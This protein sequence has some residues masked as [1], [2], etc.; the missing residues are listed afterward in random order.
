MSLLQ[1]IKKG[2]ASSGSNKGKI[3]YLKADSKT[4]VRF[5]QEV[6]D[7]LEIK[8][9]DS[10]DQG[11]TAVC[12]K[13]YKKKC[14]Y[15]N[16]DSIRTRQA[17]IWSVWDYEAKEVKLYMG[18]A[19]NFSHLPQLI[20]MYE[21]YGTIIDRDYIL[22]KDGSGTNGRFGVVPMDKVKFKNTKAKPYPSNKVMEMINKAFPYTEPSDGA[23]DDDMDDEI[24]TETEAV[25]ENE[26]SDMK[27]KDLYMECI[28]RGLKAKKKQDKDYYID[29]LLADDLENEDGEEEEDEEDEW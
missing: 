15:C 29:M 2:V 22:Q 9:H 28:E 16:D 14:A 19:N 1:S 3:V 18:Y 12:Q 21:S 20:S 25:E 4:R 11:I 17:Y 8:M 5:L 27:A 24:E 7:G 6:E 23:E 13:H 26:Y 10:F